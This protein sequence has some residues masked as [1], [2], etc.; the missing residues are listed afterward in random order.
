VFAAIG[1]LSH[2]DR[3]VAK[4]LL[5]KTLNWSEDDGDAKHTN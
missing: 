1:V 5:K 3:D 2:V 4:A